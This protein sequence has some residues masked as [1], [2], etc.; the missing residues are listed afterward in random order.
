MAESISVVIL[1]IAVV[2]SSALVV[3][4]FTVSFD[5]FSLSS[6]TSSDT[7][8]FFTFSLQSINIISHLPEDN[9]TLSAVN[10]GSD[11]LRLSSLQLRID[12]NILSNVS[13]S[14]SPDT[15]RTSIDVWE[16]GEYLD[17]F[18]QKNISPGHRSFR[19]VTL[20]S[21]YAHERTF[22]VS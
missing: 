15:L 6:R 11:S 21:G 1:F 7:L 20:P 10:T 8:Q 5:S 2:L 4:L 3:L 17:I 9:V 19:L 16:P 14:I 22:F 18:F 13:F 12:N